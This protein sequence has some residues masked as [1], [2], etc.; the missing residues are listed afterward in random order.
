MQRQSSFYRSAALTLSGRSEEQADYCNAVVEI[1]TALTAPALFAFLQ[2]IEQAMGRVRGPERWAPRRIDLDLLLY[3]NQVVALPTL[4]VPHP[5]M[6]KRD[7]VIMPL[8]EIAPRA[9]IPGIGLAASVAQ[10]LAGDGLALWE[11]GA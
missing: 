9:R 4:T 7:F 3:G 10:K 5:E 2:G 11:Q 1:R 6:H 8:L